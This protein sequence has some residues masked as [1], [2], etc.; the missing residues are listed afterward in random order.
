MAKK[1]V[2]PRLIRW[3]LLLQEFDLEIKD[4]KGTKNQVADHL[5]RLENIETQRK[6]KEIEVCFPDEKFMVMCDKE[7]WVV[8]AYHLL[9]NGQAK[10]S[11]REIKFILEKVA[12]TSRKD[13]AQRLDEALWAYLT[14]Y[15]M[16]IDMSPYALLNLDLANARDARKLQLNELVECHTTTYENAKLYKEQ[17]KKWHVSKICE[18]KSRWSEPFI[19]KEVFPNGVVELSSEDGSNV[20]KVNG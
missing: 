15:K 3:V 18:L 20:F 4:K 14:A 9:T 16:P 13:W 12:N 6:E 5:S 7:P 2:K 8:S 17:M 19:V 1:D 10:V 11:N